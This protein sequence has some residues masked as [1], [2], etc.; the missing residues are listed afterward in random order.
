MDCPV[1]WLVEMKTEKADIL[2]GNV[3]VQVKVIR[4]TVLIVG[5]KDAVTKKKIFIQKWIDYRK[6][7]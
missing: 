5:Q 3:D 7:V 4:A 2:L 1:N 6:T